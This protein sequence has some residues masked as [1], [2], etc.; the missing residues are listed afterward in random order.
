ML[1][2]TTF[3]G[4]LVAVFGLGRSGLAAAQAL[5]AGGAKPIVWD[6]AEAAIEKA[7]QIGLEV[8]DLSL[9]DWSQ[10]VALILSPG[11]PL[12]HP[13]PHPI[14]YLALNA[15]VPIIGDVELFM[16][17]RNLYASRAPV[18][19]ITGTNGKSTTTALITHVL[20][21]SGMR[22]Q[23][24]GNIGTPV[25]SLD[26]PTEDHITVIE[27]SSYQI[28][29]MKSLNFS[30]SVH[31]NLVPDHLDRHGTMEHYAEVKERLSVGSDV[32]VI[33]MDDEFSRNIAKR[34]KHAQ[35]PLIEISSMH[36]VEN[37]FFNQEGTIMEVHNGIEKAFLDLN[38]SNVLRGAHNA[39]NAAAAI[40]VAQVLG[41]KH[42]QIRKGVLSFPGLA[43]RMEPL[44][45]IGDV[46]FV[47][48]SK[49]TNAEA[50]ACALSSYNDIYWIVG[51][52]AK[53]GGIDSLVPYFQS[54]RKAYLIGSAASEFAKIFTKYNIPFIEADD[55][56]HAVPSAA[57]DAITSAD[58]APVV[59]LSPACASFDQYRNF[60]L[61][62][63]A[64]RACVNEVMKEA[65]SKGQ[66]LEEELS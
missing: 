33:G 56:A 11:I 64:F 9:I 50:A 53:Q 60:E 48:D 29:L 18:V 20:Q 31:M 2:I 12:T 41:L 8:E 66:F 17:E 15:H 59:L 55:L 6:S 42:E 47:N 37:G 49:A 65:L 5:Q 63:E 16:M 54:V 3:K 43:H 13:E 23:T 52:L 39:Q 32:A 38:E 46:Q 10:F 4:Q 28:D 27:C 19:G 45:F 14:V 36:P 58:K 21:S 7:R 40:A 51:G 25:L 22:V 61:R 26:L 30:A 35:C 1:P 34:R 57:Q 24:G 62:G 44:G